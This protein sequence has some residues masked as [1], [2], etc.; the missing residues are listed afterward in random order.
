MGW[1]IFFKILNIE[2][3]K[4]CDS[5]N[6]YVMKGQASK[7]CVYYS[8]INPALRHHLNYEIII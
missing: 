6:A 7:S 1:V 8:V 5:L 2:D 4:I 3:G